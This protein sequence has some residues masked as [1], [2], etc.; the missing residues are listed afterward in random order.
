MCRNGARLAQSTGGRLA[1]GGD[2]PP[3]AV[4]HAGIALG[5][6][7]P[8]RKTPR[9]SRLAGELAG[10]IEH[11][12]YAVFRRYCNQLTRAERSRLDNTIDNALFKIDRYLSRIA[13]PL[14]A[15][16]GGGRCDAQTRSARLARDADERTTAAWPAAPISNWPQ[17]AS[18]SPESFEEFVGE[19]FE[20][21]GFEV[22]QVGR[23]RRRRC[24]PPASP[25][26][27]A[28]CR[29]SVQVSQASRWSARPS[30][31]N[32]W[33]Q[34]ITLAATRASSSPPARFRSRPRSSP[35]NTHR[36]R[37]RPS[38]RRAC[39]MMPLGPKPPRTSPPGFETAWIHSEKGGRLR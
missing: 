35:P 13:A 15:D 28:D 22:E 37:R 6:R 33:A 21:M 39:V 25:Q 12:H 32:F 1:A 8:T 11:L 2:P 18:L 7:F 3:E 10:A 31:R 24:R 30:C 27:R 38:T 23:L 20:M 29:R 9:R 34:S 14:A 4:S 19:L 36:A 5:P 17:L 16:R 26:R